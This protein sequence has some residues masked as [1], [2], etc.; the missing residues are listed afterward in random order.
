M[1]NNVHSE[2]AIRGFYS[3]KF[4]QNFRSLFLPLSRALK[5]ADVRPNTVTVI[6]VA[7]GVITGVFLAYD[8]LWTGLIFGLAMAFADIV[9]GQLAKEFAGASRFGAVI[10]S[11]A[12]RYNEFFVFGGL[13]FRYYFLGRDLWIIACAMAFFGS[14]M[15]SYVKARAE[16]EGIECK[17]GLLQRPERLTILG[18]G[19]LFRSPGIDVAVLFLAVFSH[20]TTVQR[21]LHVCRQSRKHHNNLN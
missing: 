21:I 9:D 13:A 19:V 16:T 6:S 2:K 11:T 8:Y 12:D 10:D 14:I 1:L 17:V 5:K 20:A 7:F 4:I 3:E 15:I 18:F